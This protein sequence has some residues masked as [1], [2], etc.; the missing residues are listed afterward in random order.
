MQRFAEQRQSLYAVAGLDVDV[1]LEICHTKTEVTLL[2]H[3]LQS[4]WTAWLCQKQ[5]NNY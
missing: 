3:S 4:V 1:V 2:R 5:Q